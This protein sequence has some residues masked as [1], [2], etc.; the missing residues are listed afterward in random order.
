MFT[1]KLL[2]GE[3]LRSLQGQKAGAFHHLWFP[4]PPEC[5]TLPR[6]DIFCGLDL[7]FPWVYLSA[8]PS[9]CRVFGALQLS[10][11]LSHKMLLCALLLCAP[12]TLGPSGAVNEEVVSSQ[13]WLTGR[14]LPP[15]HTAGEVGPLLLVVFFFF[16]EPRQ[17]SN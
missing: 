6:S 1:S 15:S 10:S 3:H 4:E 9:S 7:L 5:P 11:G 8:L 17:A 12:P 2:F 16:L 14:P 13:P